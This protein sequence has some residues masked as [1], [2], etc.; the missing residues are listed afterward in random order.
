M[1][2]RLIVLV[3]E[4]NNARVD[5]GKMDGGVLGIE[6]RDVDRPGVA[7]GVRVDIITSESKTPILFS[8]Y[9]IIAILSRLIMYRLHQ[10]KQECTNHNKPN[11]NVETR[12]YQAKNK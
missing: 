12:I 1:N 7:K 5:D 6:L 3:E 8:F 10:T 11:E 4:G 9:L 2:G